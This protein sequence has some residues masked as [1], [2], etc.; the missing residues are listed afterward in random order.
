VTP[1]KPPA[2]HPYRWVIFGAMCLVYFAFGVVLLAIPPMAAD[3]RADLG[4]SRSV[5][6]FGSGCGGRSR[7][8]RC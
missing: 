7:P 2:R 5:L 6:G 8:V 4:V 3:V 1:A